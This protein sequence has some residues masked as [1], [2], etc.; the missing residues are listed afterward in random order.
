MAIGILGYGE[1]GKAVASFIKSPLIKNSRI[2]EDIFS[3]LEKE[4]EK[5]K[6]S[7]SKLPFSFVGGYVGYF[8]YE[9]KKLIGA[10][11]KYQSPYPDSLW[12]FVDKFIAFD[13]K[14]KKEHC[15]KKIY[16]SLKKNVKK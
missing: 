8:G 11:T 3:F 4:L 1:V 9:L 16:K 14:E 12:Y 13:H 7:Q 2:D 10:K 6:I 15:V 5:N